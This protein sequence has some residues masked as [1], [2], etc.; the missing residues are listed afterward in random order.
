MTPTCLPTTTRP[1]IT[2]RSDIERLV[3]TFYAKIRGD[4]LLGFIFNDVAQALGNTGI[5]PIP[6]A[7][8]APATAAILLGLTLVFHQEDG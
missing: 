6:L 1:D 8:A 4:E 3:D 5:L 7:A 2:S